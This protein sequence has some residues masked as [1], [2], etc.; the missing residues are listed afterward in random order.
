MSRLRPVSRLSSQGQ[1][2]AMRLQFPS[3]A[4]DQQRPQTP[5]NPPPLPVRAARIPRCGQARNQRW[6]AYRLRQSTAGEAS[7]SRCPRT[8]G[9]NPP[10]QAMVQFLYR[11][12][13][14][15]SPQRGEQ[16]LPISSAQLAPPNPSPYE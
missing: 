5:P 6:S 13:G 4:E 8:Q 15:S 12:N 14:R 2:L 10:P 9:T 3:S 7:S 11:A 16:S 1:R